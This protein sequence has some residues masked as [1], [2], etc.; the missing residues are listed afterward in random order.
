MLP[1]PSALLLLMA[2]LACLVLA[3]CG[4]D[5]EDEVAEIVYEAS[6]IAGGVQVT[7][8]FVVDPETFETRQLTD[9]EGYDGQ[10]AWTPGRER[11]MF[12]S[13]RGQE[14]NMTDIYTMLPDGRDVQRVTSTPDQAE[15]SPKFSPDGERIAVVVN[16]DSQYWLG[17]I[18]PDGS[19]EELI[20]GPYDF[21]EF[22]AWTRDGALIYFA[23]ITDD[24]QSIDI[25]SVDPQT[26]EVRVRISTPSPDVCP[27]FTHDG[28]YM[29][30][31]RSPVSPNEE[32]D[33][34]RHDLDSDDTTGA[35]D[36]RL[37]DSPGRD[38][39][40]NPSPD[41]EQFVFLSNRDGN[42]DLYLMDADGANV[43]KLTSTPDLRENVPDW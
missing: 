29:T 27:H 38:D 35:D 16:K 30:Y 34:F 6:G 36:V 4:D 15:R 31:A 14:R 10:P 39:Y 7:N 28:E 42:F 21:I 41:D 37:T 1:R 33:V 25:L 22:P 23:A 17:I 9:A 8:V 2:A 24:S 26:R 43:R 5:G 40:A 18:A 32:P 12:I 20:A 19:G 13:D 3:A 11:I